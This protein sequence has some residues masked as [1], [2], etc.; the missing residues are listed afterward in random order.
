MDTTHAP[1]PRRIVV[2][3]PC[4]SG[5]TT[6]SHR[7]R[8][9][10]FDAHACGQEHSEIP[11][12]WAHQEPEVLVGLRID[13]K[14]LRRRRSASWSDR[15]YAKQL[16]RLRSGYDHADL[17]IDADVNDEDAVLDAVLSWLRDH[18]ESGL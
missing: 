9:L 15:L 18:E 14:T 7:L 8:A 17:V 1:D 3:G 13:L 2:I 16:E 4:G 6:L 12:L 10:G 11:E 5:K